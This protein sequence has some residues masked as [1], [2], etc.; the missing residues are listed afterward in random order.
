MEGLGVCGGDND[1]VED[2]LACDA[3]R[4]RFSA[5]CAPPEDA[6]RRSCAEAGGDVAA[7]GEI[8]ALKTKCKLVDT[9]KGPKYSSL[10]IQALYCVLHGL[11]SWPTAV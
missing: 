11:V 1:P 5:W 8:P 7:V 9:C 2:L 6:A 4:L 3:K 10:N